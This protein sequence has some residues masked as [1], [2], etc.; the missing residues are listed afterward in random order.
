MA[1]QALFEE[2][3]GSTGAGGRGVQSGR[4]HRYFGL[5]LEDPLPIGSVS[6]SSSVP[7]SISLLYYLP[8][9]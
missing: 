6:M 2:A 7:G 5:S 8:V 1:E 3:G 4:I 9:M